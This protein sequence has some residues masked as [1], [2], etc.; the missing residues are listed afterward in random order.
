[1]TLSA[2]HHNLH[3][4][5]TSRAPGIGLGV[6][7]LANHDLDHPCQDTDFSGAVPLDTGSQR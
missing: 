6:R 5:T 4:G 2:L 1:M 7:R 3:D